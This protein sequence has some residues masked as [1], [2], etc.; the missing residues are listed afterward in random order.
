MLLCVSDRVKWYNFQSPLFS[1]QRPKVHDFFFNYAS[2]NA[3][4]SSKNT[5]SVTRPIVS[6]FFTKTLK[7]QTDLSADLWWF[8]QSH[9]HVSILPNEY[10]SRASSLAEFHHKNMW[11]SCVAASHVLA[12]LP[13]VDDE[14]NFLLWNLFSCPGNLATVFCRRPCHLAVALRIV[15][16]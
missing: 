14:N 12:T 2:Q 9:T 10:W 4:Q 3:P 11:F 15:R 13:C 1:V 6:I 8:E 5:P 16:R 7:E